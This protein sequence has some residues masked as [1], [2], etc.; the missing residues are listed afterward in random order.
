[1]GIRVSKELEAEILARADRIGPSAVMEQPAPLKAKG[2]VHEPGRMNKGEAQYADH[3][4]IRRRAGEIADY[5]YEAVKLRLADRTYYTPDFMVMLKDGTI[6]FH[7]VK[8]TWSTGKAGFKEDARVKI[9]VAA[10]QFPMFAFVV[11]N[12]VKNTW[13]E[14]RL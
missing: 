6:E 8:A 12:K 1:M 7:E 10:E 5:R 11:V 9:K 3:L 14:E 4:E 2:V 13:N